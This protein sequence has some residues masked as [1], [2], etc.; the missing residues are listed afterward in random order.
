MVTSVHANRTSQSP[1]RISRAFCRTDPWPY[2]TVGTPKSRAS[3]SQ[4]KKV[5]TAVA[6]RKPPPWSHNKVPPPT[7]SSL[8]SRTS[9]NLRRNSVAGVRVTLEPKS[10]ARL[11][12]TAKNLELAAWQHL[13]NVARH[14]PRAA[15]RRRN[16][17]YRRRRESR[18]SRAARSWRAALEVRSQRSRPSA[19]AGPR[20]W[21]WRPRST[22]APTMTP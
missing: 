21:Q 11:G 22:L 1:R 9:A 14:A 18:R 5:M 15:P 17:P 6:S 19:T 8:L 2:N 10:R 12:A 20:R 13:P 3:R 4:K 7:T 16:F